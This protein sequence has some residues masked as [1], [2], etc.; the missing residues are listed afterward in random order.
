[1]RRGSRPV[2]HVRGVA[3]VGAG[4]IKVIGRL[5][6]YDA[7]HHLGACFV[8]ELPAVFLNASTARVARALR[9]K[10]TAELLQL[11]ELLTA[12]APLRPIEIEDCLSLYRHRLETIVADP[13]VA[14]SRGEVAEKAT[15]RR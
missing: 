1:M 6:V 5:T 11:A 10:H 9:V 15:D 4:A 13:S 8:L 2:P 14:T 7:P 3:R 12:F